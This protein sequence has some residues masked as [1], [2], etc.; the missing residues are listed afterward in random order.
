MLGSKRNF[1]L[2]VLPTLGQGLDCQ[3]FGKLMRILY[4]KPFQLPPS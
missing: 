2:V 3:A 4:I 1:L